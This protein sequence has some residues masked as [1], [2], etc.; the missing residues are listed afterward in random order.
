MISKLIRR[1]YTLITQ[2]NIE[3]SVTE[4]TFKLIIIDKRNLDKS[5]Q[6]IRWVEPSSIEWQDCFGI[7]RC[8]SKMHK[9][10]NVNQFIPHLLK[11]LYRGVVFLRLCGSFVVCLASIGQPMGVV[12]PAPPTAASATT[13]WPPT[14]S[15]ASTGPPTTAA[16]A[17]SIAGPTATTTTVG[18]PTPATATP[19]NRREKYAKNTDI[20]SL[21]IKLVIYKYILTY[22]LFVITGYKL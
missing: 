21:I 6:E 13:P 2:C 18:L 4:I 1:S 8:A 20:F 22:I 12:V 15:T 5:T 16:A 10:S 14:A 11:K 7:S 17:S 19:Y 3:T 9:I